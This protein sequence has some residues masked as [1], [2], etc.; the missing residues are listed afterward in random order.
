VR[1]ESND[2]LVARDSGQHVVLALEGVLL[3]VLALQLVPQRLR[4][5]WVWE[6]CSGEQ[7]RL[8]AVNSYACTARFSDTTP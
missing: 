3:W 5:I 4:R 8:E 1:P 7:A 2:V 6:P